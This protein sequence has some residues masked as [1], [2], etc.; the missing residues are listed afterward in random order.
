MKPLLISPEN[1]YQPWSPRNKMRRDVNLKH[2]SASGRVARAPVVED[3]DGLDFDVVHFAQQQ[4]VLHIVPAGFCHLCALVFKDIIKIFTR[5]DDTIVGLSVADQLLCVKGWN[6]LIHK[7][8]VN[9][10]VWLYTPSNLAPI[11]IF[12]KTEKTSFTVCSCLP[13]HSV[14]FLMHGNW[15]AIG[16]GASA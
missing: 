11:L 2:A 10:H 9:V 3:Y 5:S 13:T 7:Q 8:E 14:D 15:S 12:V 16:M 1:V 6:D 4:L